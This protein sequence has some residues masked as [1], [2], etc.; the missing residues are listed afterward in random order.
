MGHHKHRRRMGQC[1][2]QSRRSPGAKVGEALRPLW[3]RLARH[4]GG[5]PRGHF[6]SC[7]RAPRTTLPA[8]RPAASRAGPAPRQPHWPYRGRGIAGR[9]TML[10]MPR[11]C[12]NF[13]AAPRLR[14]SGCVQRN[15]GAALAAALG[16]PV[17][18]AMAEEPKGAG[19]EHA[20]PFSPSAAIARCT[21]GRAFIRA[22]WGGDIRRQRHLGP[23]RP[24]AGVEQGGISH[25]IFAG[26]P[27]LALECVVQDRHALGVDL[28]PAGPAPVSLSDSLGEKLAGRAMRVKPCMCTVATT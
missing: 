6:G 10:A 19:G 17:R 13:A 14:H 23:R 12:S 24:V 28:P 11:R 27:L 2:R 9:R 4:P 22:K 8:G 3:G 25:G 26:D 1:H 18:F 15:V 21:A 20:Q 7:L 16:I 5:E